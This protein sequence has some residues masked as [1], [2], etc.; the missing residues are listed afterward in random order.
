MGS[1]TAA[2]ILFVL[3]VGL[4][5]GGIMA[6]VSRA[7]RSDAGSKGSPKPRE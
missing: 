1:F 2:D 7:R 4:L 6:L 5:V 3:L